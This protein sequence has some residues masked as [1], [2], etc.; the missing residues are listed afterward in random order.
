MASPPSPAYLSVVKDYFDRS[1][2]HVRHQSIR[3]TA[4]CILGMCDYLKQFPGASDIKR[5]LELAADHLVSQYHEARQADWEW[6]EDGLCYD[7]GVVPHALLATAVTLENGKYAEVAM[8]T[9]EFLLDHT[10]DGDHF[11]LIGSQG[12]Y[13]RGGARAT[14]DQQ[15]IDAA[16]TVMMLRA[17]YDV[18]RD[19]RFLSL[20]Q[21]AFDWF[22]GTNDLRIPLYDFRTKGCSD[23]LM[24]D[25]LNGNQGA[26]SMISFLL[27]LLTVL[28]TC[29][30]PDGTQAEKNA[31]WLNVPLLEAIAKTP[32]NIQTA[33]DGKA[34]AQNRG[35]EP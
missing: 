5:Q 33:V 6:F 17:A 1:I 10:F 32:G 4:Y 35:R 30:L 34:A 23:G 29:A 28:D 20:Q 14:F 8:K 19:R 15:P 26:E 22:L 31:A 12:W 27:S 24:A 18:T 13:P 21:T 2:G 9:T 7:N 25:G 3:G 16:A 11:S